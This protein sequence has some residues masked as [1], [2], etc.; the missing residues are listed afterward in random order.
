MCRV[1]RVVKIFAAAFL[2][3]VALVATSRYV[4]SVDLAL[5]LS[6]ISEIPIY[7]LVLALFA[8]SLGPLL[9][10]AQFY[11]V[12]KSHG[13]RLGFKKVLLGM[14][15]TLALEY[16]VPIG[17]ATEAGRIAFL[18]YEGVPPDRALQITFFHRLAH[19]A[20][21][22]VELAFVVLLTMRIDRFVL[23]LL[24]ATA[25]VNAL[26]LSAVASIKLP[27]VSRFLLKYVS[28]LGF[29]G[30]ESASTAIPMRRS[31]SAV[32]LAI[33]LEKISLV[34]SGYLLLS[35]LDKSASLLHSIL[36]FD[37]LLVTFWLLPIVTPA[38]I[39]QVETVQLLASADMNLN[40][41]SALSAIILYRLITTV[42][43]MPQ[44]LPAFIKYGA[45][46]L[47]RTSNREVCV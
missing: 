37:I 30:I 36:V 19:S 44:L 20:F 3:V 6:Y 45:G 11:L 33:G 46:V 1:K 31:I 5:A 7:L 21:I 35:Y 32:F 34:I 26:N 18:V 24:L 22:A 25:V 47:T 23:W 8:R 28:K 17:G 14:Y 12:I 13:Y 38:G 39:G 10:S 42:S 16:V 41:N 15:S 9:H 43:I 27:K 4:L 40:I 2:G 29:R